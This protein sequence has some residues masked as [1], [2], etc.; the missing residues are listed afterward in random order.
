MTIAMTYGAARKMY[1]L[2]DAKVERF[3]KPLNKNCEYPLLSLMRPM[4][5]TEK[6]ACVVVSSCMSVY[7]M[8]FNLFKDLIYLELKAKKLVNDQDITQDCT[9]FV[10]YM[11][12]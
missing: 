9:T 3:Y 1:Q 7:V 10:D 4:T 6:T 2:R 5:Y 11:L 12:L 8:P